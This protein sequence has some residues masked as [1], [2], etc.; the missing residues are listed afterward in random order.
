MPRTRP[1]YPQRFKRAMV[2]LVKHGKNATELAEIFEPA[3]ATIR[4]WTEKIEIEH[5]TAIGRPDGDEQEKLRRLKKKNRVLT[6]VVQLLISEDG[7]PGF[8]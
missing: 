2:L 7:S 3:A 6:E 8:S 1:P 5:G 4:N